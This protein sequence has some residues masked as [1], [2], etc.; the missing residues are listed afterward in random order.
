MKKLTLALSFLLVAFV[1]Q[2][3]EAESE[4]QN[5]D[6]WSIDVGGGFNK[7]TR[8]MVGFT[9]TP[10]VWNADLGV[11]YMINNKFGFFI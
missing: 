8:P 1:V 2:A 4:L 5:Y 3:Q 11:R 6:H 7:P 10:S 9:D